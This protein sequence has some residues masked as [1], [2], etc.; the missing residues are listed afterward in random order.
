MGQELQRPIDSFGSRRRATVVVIVFFVGAVAFTVARGYLGF[1]LEWYR[2]LDGWLSG[3]AWVDQYAIWTMAILVG[4][5]VAHRMG[6]RRALGE[7]GLKAPSG[8]AL[9]FAIIATIPMMAGAA[10]MGTFQLRWELVGSSLF[11]PFFEELLF[12]G[13][14]MRQLHRRGGLGMWPA[15]FFTGIVFG[16][17]HAVHALLRGQM[18][19]FHL[20]TFAMTGAGGVFYAWLFASWRDNLWLPIFLHALMNLSWLLF[21]IAGEAVGGIWSNVCRALTVATAIV[22]TLFRDRFERLWVGE[23]SQ[24]R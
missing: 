1:Y 5:G 18:S 24:S 4:L 15:A 23:G 21:G 12:R 9:V 19:W 13:Y 10:L 20:G 14:A 3:W 6:P 22:L 2:I 8:R 11:A 7:L 17:V 16:L